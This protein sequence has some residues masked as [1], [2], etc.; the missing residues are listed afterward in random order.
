MPDL[1]ESLLVTPSTHVRIPLTP[2][3]SEHLDFDIVISVMLLCS[4]EGLWVVSL[5]GGSL[6]DWLAQCMWGAGL[7]PS[8][9]LERTDFHCCSQGWR[10]QGWRFPV[11]QVKDLSQVFFLENHKKDSGVWNKCSSHYV[12]D[13]GEFTNS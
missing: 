2:S 9:T 5:L 11:S 1:P 3:L 6:T 13:D 7:P 12:L 10:T 4:P 8:H